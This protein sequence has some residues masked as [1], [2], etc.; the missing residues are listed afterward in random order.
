MGS[1]DIVG[2]WPSTGNVHDALET[3]PEFTGFTAVMPEE[4]GQGQKEVARADSE[5]P[6]VPLGQVIVSAQTDAS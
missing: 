2:R 4:A 6:R 5:T 1:R 3:P